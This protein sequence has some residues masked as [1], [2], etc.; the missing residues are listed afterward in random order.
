MSNEKLQ[1]LEARLADLE[2]RPNE[3]DISPV[4]TGIALSLMMLVNELRAAKAIDPERFLLVLDSAPEI[5]RKNAPAQFS[6]GTA[7]GDLALRVFEQLNEFFYGTLGAGT[8]PAPTK[9]FKPIVI[10]GGKS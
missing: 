1:E 10:K 9:P 5:I 3:I 4:V 2:D 7:S 8:K 6:L